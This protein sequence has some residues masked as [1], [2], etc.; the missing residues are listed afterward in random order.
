MVLR[1]IG[2][3]DPPVVLR[4]RPRSFEVPRVSRAVLQEAPIEAAM[5]GA[6]AA[7][8]LGAQHAHQPTSFGLFI[9]S[10]ALLLLGVLQ[11]S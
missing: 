9:A 5:A 3:H 8:G 10:G 2:L 1:I 11:D 7:F 4:L 6:L